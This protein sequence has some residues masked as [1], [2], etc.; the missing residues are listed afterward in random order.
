M[1][2]TWIK[3]KGRVTRRFIRVKIALDHRSTVLQK[4]TDVYYGKAEVDTSLHM[5]KNV[6]AV[7]GL[8][9]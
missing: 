9:S 3:M 2:T 8:N 6:S 1:Q 7:K 4:A 5:Y